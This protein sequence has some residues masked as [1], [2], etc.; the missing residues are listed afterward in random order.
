MLVD[1]YAEIPT[2]LHRVEAR[3]KSKTIFVSGAAH[4]YGDKITSDQ[5]LGFV[6]KLSK[7]LVKEKFRLVTGLGLGIGSTVVDGALQQIYWE[8]RRTITDELVIRPFPQ[9]SEGKKLWRVYRE[10]L[11]E[12]A[13]IAVF[14][15]G[16]KIAGDL[17]AVAP[18]NGMVDE[19][20]IAVSKGLRVLP[21]GFTGFVAMDLWKQVKAD[22]GSFYPGA[23][24]RFHALFEQL[25]DDGFDLELQASAVLEAL[26][27]LQQM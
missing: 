5:A 24:T 16:N 15:F 20:N 8:E 25:G 1:E 4:T 23:S 3:Y 12:F 18:S 2:V 9:S 6:H 7:S 19:F 14:M 21:L 10:D 26:Q 22:F 13:G 11:L 17:L 27:I